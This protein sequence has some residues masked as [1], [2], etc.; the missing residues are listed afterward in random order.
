MRFSFP[1]LYENHQL[2]LSFRP[3][4]A[5][6]F[7]RELQADVIMPYLSPKAPSAAIPV[8]MFLYSRAFRDSY[9]IDFLH[10]EC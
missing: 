3:S 5:E 2:S 9:F 1:I 7:L 10:R 8:G 6:V 4:A